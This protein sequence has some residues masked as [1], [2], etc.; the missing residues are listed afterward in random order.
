MRVRCVTEGQTTTGVTMSKLQKATDKA[1]EQFQQA[2]PHI[3]AAR[4]ILAEALGVDPD[5]YPGVVPGKSSEH[6]EA[7]RLMQNVWSAYMHVSDPFGS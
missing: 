5:E 4:A 7:V 6:W 2:L 3:E 1:L